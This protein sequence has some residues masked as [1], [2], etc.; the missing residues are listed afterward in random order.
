[1]KN[2]V[3]KKTKNV[4]ESDIIFQDMTEG[5][6][7][8]NSV[9]VKAQIRNAMEIQRIKIIKDLLDGSLILLVVA[10]YIYSTYEA[11]SFKDGHM[12]WYNYI[13]FLIH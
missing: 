4:S 2:E 13:N 6:M 8:R 11:D 9:S 10:M 3:V 5:S 1:M 12:N 7:S